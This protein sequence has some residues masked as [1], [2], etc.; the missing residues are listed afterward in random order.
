MNHSQKV[1]LSDHQDRKSEK[2]FS[3][4]EKPKVGKEEELYNKNFACVR[5]F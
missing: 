2:I 1:L 3:V 5:D 4:Q